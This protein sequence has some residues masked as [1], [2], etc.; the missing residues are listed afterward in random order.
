[1]SDAPRHLHAFWA[2]VL[3][4]ALKESEIEGWKRVGDEWK[5]A[6][7][8]RE[9]K[10]YY[11]S[12]ACEFTR[13]S[14]KVTT[15]RSLGHSAAAVSVEK[16][17]KIEYT[18]RCDSLEGKAVLR[19][20]LIPTQA[21]DRGDIRFSATL[22]GQRQVFSLKEPYRSETWKENVSRAQARFEMEVENLGEGEHILTL[23]ALDGNIIFD[24]WMLDSK[25]GRKFYVF[26]L[27][28]ER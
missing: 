12:S 24:Q 13:S 23:E 14:G 16:G 20:A 8:E 2:P 5:A 26:P 6:G 4:V 1:M 25:I 22:D 10:D 7:S 21:I 27:A 19:L 18:F 9:G 17:G 11:A 15:I 28:P 3:P